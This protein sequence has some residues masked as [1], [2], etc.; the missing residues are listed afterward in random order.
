[1]NSVKNEVLMFNQERDWDQFHSLD[2]LAKSIAI[3]AGE[4]LECFQWSNDYTK[5]AVC[6]ELADIVNYC[7]L[8][9]NKLDV[10]LDQIVLNKLEKNR[11]KYPIEKARGIST[12]YDK[13]GSD[14][15][16]NK[17]L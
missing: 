14:Y 13:L 9:A 7:I 6:D 2:N 12:K 17:D 5:E 4:L 1:M 16:P 3:E 11:L 8:L 15:D 10:D